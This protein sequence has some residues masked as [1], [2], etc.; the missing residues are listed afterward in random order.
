MHF[1]FDQMQLFERYK[2]VKNYA[3]GGNGKSSVVSAED[4]QSYWDIY[5]N[6]NSIFKQV[7]ATSKYSADFVV[8][9]HNYSKERGVRGHRPKSIW[10]AFRN[11]ESHVFN[12]MPQIYVVLSE[13]G[14]ET[15]FAVS[16]PESDYHDQNIKIQNREII[17]Q[18]HKK[19]PVSGSLIDSL[20]HEL[21]RSN[22]WSLR[23]KTREKVNGSKIPYNNSV[24]AMFDSLKQEK[25]CFGGGSIASNTKP[26]RKNKSV[27]VGY[28][29]KNA[30][31]AFGDILLTCAP[32]GADIEFANFRDEIEKYSPDDVFWKLNKFD[33]REYH[34]RSVA[35]RVGQGKFRNA[36][37]AA[38]SHRCA[39]TETGQR[40][41][42]QAAHIYPY[43][44]ENG[45]NVANGILLRSDL[46]L[47]FDLHMISVHPE[48]HTIFVSDRIEDRMYKTLG[49]KKIA[50][51]DRKNERPSKQS[52]QWHFDQFQIKQDC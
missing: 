16:I 15:G 48:E 49:G 2:D 19:L 8:K 14:V 29:A 44:G 13:E 31:D 45:N 26:T 33:T 5:Q 50:L 43:K 34:L 30:L 32:T 18:I 37:L 39:F 51:P 41:V 47:L 21:D 25:V 24:A 17:P 20:Q 27:N 52:L 3:F 42:L 11:K 46:H 1:S 35:L 23:H 9:G 36:V 38:Y 28:W 22:K 10:C 6:L 4:K 7:L 40:D 12:Q